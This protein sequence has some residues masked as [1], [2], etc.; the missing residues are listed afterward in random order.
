[1]QSLTQAHERQLHTIFL[2]FARP[3]AAPC[4]GLAELSSFLCSLQGSPYPGAPALLARY[5]SNGAI[6]FPSFLQLVCNEP[7]PGLGG[8]PLDS[9]SAVRQ[10]LAAVFSAADADGDSQLSAAEVQALM[11]ADGAPVSAAEVAAV[12]EEAGVP[13]GK[14]M[15]LQ[16]LIALC[17]NTQVV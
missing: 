14:G 5:G 17:V 1:M 8:S 4:L 3:S 15:T 6:T 9:A 16:Q 2:L 7:L 10:E 11:Q 12:M 13:Q